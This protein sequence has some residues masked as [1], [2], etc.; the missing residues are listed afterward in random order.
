VAS[1]VQTKSGAS[2]LKVQMENDA[3]RKRLA[4]LQG[5]SLPVPTNHPSK[6]N[7]TS[8]TDPVITAS[9]RPTG[10]QIQIGATDS[11]ASAVRLLS[12]AQAKA[13]KTLASVSFHTETVSKNSAVLHRARFVGFSNKQAA[14]NACKILKKRK[15]ACLA[16]SS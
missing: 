4:E 10:W 15:F 8:K 14:R 5:K 1:A 12:K 9:V 11:K 6:V 16:I 13:P 2:L 3:I 7:V